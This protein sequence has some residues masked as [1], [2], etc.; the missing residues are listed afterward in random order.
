MINWILTSCFS[1]EQ[2]TASV[3]I[4]DTISSGEGNTRDL[5][6]KA[7]ESWAHNPYDRRK[8]SFER[9][10]TVPFSNSLS[11]DKLML[12][13][14]LCLLLWRALSPISPASD[15][16]S[17]SISSS[18]WKDLVREKL[19]ERLLTEEPTLLAW[20]NDS[21]RLGL[22]SLVPRSITQTQTTVLNKLN[23]QKSINHRPYTCELY[24]T[25]HFIYWY[26]APKSIQKQMQ[27]LQQLQ[28]NENERGW[29]EFINKNKKYCVLVTGQS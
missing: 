29:K 28:I 1:L 2:T 14:S 15:T 10:N 24:R 12:P 8:L 18:T 16:F 26:P 6:F 9:G 19:K 20:R 17:L 4:G 3:E 23:Q 25:L 22:D 5:V 13:L 7:V 11:M 21:L 27:W